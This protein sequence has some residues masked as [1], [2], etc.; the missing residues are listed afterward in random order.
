MRGLW[1]RLHALTAVGVTPLVALHSA[2]AETSTSL[3]KVEC[4]M[5]L[6]YPDDAA[7]TVYGY[8]ARFPL[9]YALDPSQPQGNAGTLGA[10]EMES[11]TIH[12]IPQ[13]AS[14]DPALARPVQSTSGIETDYIAVKIQRQGSMPVTF[15]ATTSY[16]DFLPFSRPSALEM[17]AVRTKGNTTI[18]RGGTD[19][20]GH[21]NNMKLTLDALAEP[22]TLMI[23]DERGQTYHVANYSFDPQKLVSRATL[24]FDQGRAAYEG[25]P[26]DLT[27]DQHGG[28]ENCSNAEG[29][30]TG[31]CFLTTATVHTLGLPDDC[32]ELRQLRAF[33]DRY[34]GRGS[35]QAAMMADYYRIAPEI[36]RRIDARHD[37]VK[38]WATVYL[39]AILPAAV[40]ASLGCDRAALAIYRKLVCTLQT[41]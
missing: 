27:P 36:V 8:D 16:E 1:K 35:A 25:K 12:V 7:K 21:A 28:L 18:A 6:Y 26:Y 11:M 30:G 5:D 20:N 2:A 37:H 33:R 39:K 32:W 3:D 17:F 41:L 19:H 31:S 34:A 9:L 13:Q 10:P 15:E 38:V 40:A 23:V 29:Y 22:F 14:T 24:A 4:W